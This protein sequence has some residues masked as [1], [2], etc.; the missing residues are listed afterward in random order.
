M[1]PKR[2]LRQR[3]LR[4][5]SHHA[6]QAA[7]N[8][9][10]LHVFDTSRDICGTAASGV[11]TPGRCNKPAPDTGSYEQDRARLFATSK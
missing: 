6:E 7:T 3:H 9:T 1:S 10:V 5:H 11:E 2:W 4:H 8:A